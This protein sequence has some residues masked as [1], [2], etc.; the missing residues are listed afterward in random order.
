MPKPSL[1]L[2]LTEFPPSYGGMQT[3]AA[4]MAAQLHATGCEILVLTY[5]C[6]EAEA[7]AAESFDRAQAYPVRRCLSRLAYWSNVAL[8]AKTAREQ[9][10]DAIYS[11]TVYFGQAA[12]R[13]KIP[14]VCRSAGNDVLRPWI[15]WPFRPASGLLNI[16][17]F[18][19]SLYPWLRKRNWPE[20]FDAFLLQARTAVMRESALAMRHVSAN[21]EFS[22]RALLKLGVSPENVD[23]VPG[24]VDASRFSPGSPSRESLGWPRDAFVLFTACRLVEKKGL[25]ALLEAMASLCPLHPDLH[26]CVAGDGPERARLESQ[27]HALGIASRVHW[28]GRLDVHE[29]VLAYRSADLFVFPSHT[30]R[31]SNGW[32]DA[33]TMGRVLCEANASG[34]PALASASGGIP[35]VIRDGKNGLLFAEGDAEALRDAIETLMANPGLRARLATEGRKRALRDFNWPRIVSRQRSVIARVLLNN[36]SSI[37]TEKAGVAKPQ[38]WE[39]D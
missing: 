4:E 31:Q 37:I 29:L 16:A 39:A 11:S 24:G 25:P 34:L 20:R 26:L 10:A 17:F 22:R 9:K 35:S 36:G 5:R 30:V 38:A 6:A 15:A 7:A 12:K 8:I 33:E 19:R 3:H 18:E 13:A 1:L 2:V 21:S 27:A 23:C 14:I 28:C 32:I